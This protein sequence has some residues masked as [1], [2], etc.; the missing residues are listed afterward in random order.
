MTEAERTLDGAVLFY[1]NMS[2]N[3][4]L[5]RRHDNLYSHTLS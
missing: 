4:L 5:A 3:A 2:Q 1:G